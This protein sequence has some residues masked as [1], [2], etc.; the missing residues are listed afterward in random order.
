M[1]DIEK[2]TGMTDAEADYW[3][4]Y[5]TANPPTVDPARN[6]IKAAHT[7]RLTVTLTMD[8]GLI[9]RINS[10][11]ESHHQ[12]PSELVTELVQHEIALPLPSFR[13]G[14]RLAVKKTLDYLVGIC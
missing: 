1:T 10:M 7:G 8:M 13:G 11:A 9:N 3:D 14:S 12:T 5:F 4:E 6:R 2:K